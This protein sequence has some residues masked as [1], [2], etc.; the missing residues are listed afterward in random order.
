MKDN[1]SILIDPGHGGYRNGAFAKQPGTDSLVYEKDINF[2]LGCLIE[3]LS[4]KTPKIIADLTRNDD[5]DISLNDRVFTSKT[6][7]IM[8][9]V[10]CNSYEFDTPSGFEIHHNRSEESTE[11]ANCILKA[12]NNNIVSMINRGLKQSDD[13]YI[14][15]KSHCPAVIVEC[16]FMSNAKDLQFLI[17]P[18]NQIKIAKT[19]LAGA[20]NYLLMGEL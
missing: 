14:L 7:D 4:Y 11:L 13:L 8:I 2:I 6:Y 3:T 10:H 18:K 20:K 1:Y 17:N 12:L 5:S 9:S 16:G 15:N 19:I